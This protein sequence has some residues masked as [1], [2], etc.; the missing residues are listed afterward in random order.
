[1]KRSETVYGQLHT[2]TEYP[3]PKPENLTPQQQDK[4]RVDCGGSARLYTPG[5]A[6]INL[7]QM[8]PNPVTVASDLSDAFHIDKKV[9]Y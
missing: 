7:S 5:F 3:Q 8:P 2:I 9:K 4:K 6:Q 1:M